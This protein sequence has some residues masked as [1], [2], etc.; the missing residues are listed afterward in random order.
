MFRLDDKHKFSIHSPL[1]PMFTSQTQLLTY[2]V[3]CFVLGKCHSGG[4]K[5]CQAVKM[6]NKQQ[7]QQKT[8]QT[9]KVIQSI[10]DKTILISVALVCMS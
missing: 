1:S 6:K 7:Q 4:F 10:V 8:K 3:C 9:C 2:F 5:L